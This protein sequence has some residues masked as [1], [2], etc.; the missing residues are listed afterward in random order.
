[1]SAVIESG[2]CSRRNCS[3]PSTLS[4]AAARISGLVEEGLLVRDFSQM[5]L[6]ERLDEFVA[7]Q[8]ED[9]EDRLSMQVRALTAVTE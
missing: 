1:L 4:S 2:P 7:G 6:S 9:V 8:R 3:K 5:L